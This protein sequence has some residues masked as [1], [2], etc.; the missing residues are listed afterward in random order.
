[1]TTKTLI[2]CI[3]PE[4]PQSSLGEVVLSPMGH[5]AVYVHPTTNAGVDSSE[6]LTLG[7]TYEIAFVDTADDRSGDVLIGI[8]LDNK[9]LEFSVDSFHFIPEDWALA[10]YVKEKLFNHERDNHRYWYGCT[11]CGDRLYMHGVAEA[12][13]TGVYESPSLKRDLEIVPRRF[14][15][16]ELDAALMESSTPFTSDN[17]IVCAANLYYS[18]KLGKEIMVPGRRHFSP[19]MHAVLDGLEEAGILSSRK[20]GWEGFMD[21]KGNFLSREHALIVA[22]ESKQ[23]NR[24]CGGDRIALYSENLY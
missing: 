8:V 14:T 2:N 23:I 15:D 12:F 21:R 11:N 13:F 20:L 7:E 19:E 1:M 24:R 16:E 4:A 3:N 9:R 17:W 18:E 6:H 22:V 5:R 10:V